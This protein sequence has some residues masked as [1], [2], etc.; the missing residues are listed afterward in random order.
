VTKQRSWTRGT[1]VAWSTALCFSDP[2]SFQAAI[3]TADLELLPTARGHFRA[4]LTKVCMNQLWVQRCY[5]N[6][7]LMIAGAMK[8]R[9]R[10][11]T[12]LT[13][14]EP[15]AMRHCGMDIVS[16]D[17]IV[18][19]FDEIHQQTEAEFRLGSISL[20]TDDFDAVCNA[21]VGHEFPGDKLKLVVRPN[22]ELMSRLTE[23]HRTVGQ[24]AKT[25]PA[26]VELPQ[27]SR[28]LEQQLVHL[29]VRCVTE[30]APLKIPLG[31]SRHDTIVAR[32]E[33]FLEANPNTPLYLP[34]IC[35][36]IGAAE[37]TLRAACE[38][39]LG[40]G[41]IRY[42]TLR[43]MHLVRRA[44]LRADGSTTVTRIA[45][46]HGFWE[47]G[48]FSVAYRTLFGETPSDSLRR[49]SD[50]PRV[51]LNRPSSLADNFA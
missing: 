16:G 1:T 14:A 27:V 7:P 29:I 24:I 38:E 35:A 37:R 45:T 47:L 20:T 18:N 39:H 9:R 23:L 50:N 17:I 22:P 30:G 42:L 32:F 2:L 49:P 6:L 10:V 40:M 12:F 11:F 8:P 36:A 4:E 3:S 26:I 5:Q 13:S 48:R 46:D 28:A 25:T 44:L 33:A 51:L 31:A 21:I 41:P 43:R 19:T 15:E 34:E